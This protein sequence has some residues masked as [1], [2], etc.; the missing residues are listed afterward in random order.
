[1]DYLSKFMNNC[2]NSGKSSIHDITLAA[3]NRIEEIEQ[4][5]NEIEELKKEEKT[6]KSLIKQLGGDFQKEET[7]V[8]QSSTAF[9]SLDSKIQNISLMIIH[10]MNDVEESSVR[11]II[12]SISSLEDSKFVLTALKWLIDNK[13]LNRNEQNRNIYKGSLWSEKQNFLRTTNLKD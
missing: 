12:D 9:S 13:I 1:M 4:R 3:K 10:F 7:I 6:L 5:L 2:L 11:N 8:F